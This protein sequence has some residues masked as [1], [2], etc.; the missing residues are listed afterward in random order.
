MLNYSRTWKEDMVTQ[1][2]RCASIICVVTWG[3][4]SE[5]G[6][7]FFMELF[8]PSTSFCGDSGHMVGGGLLN[9]EVITETALVRIPQSAEC[10]SCLLLA[11]QWL[12]RYAKP[13][14]CPR[15]SRLRT[16]SQPRHGRLVSTNGLFP[17]FDG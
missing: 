17:H 15:G 12:G 6:S 1:R 3:L 8:S 16:G 7:L 11:P 13:R 5:K 2:R 9:K 4:N 14:G 10:H